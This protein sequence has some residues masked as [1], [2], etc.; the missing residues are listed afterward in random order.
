MRQTVR[1]ILVIVA[2]LLLS[3]C[4]AGDNRSGFEKVMD[5]FNMMGAGAF[6]GKGPTAFREAREVRE[7]KEQNLSQSVTSTWCEDSIIKDGMEWTEAREI[8]NKKYLSGELSGAEW[9]MQE[10]VVNLKVEPD[11]LAAKTKIGLCLTQLVKSKT[12]KNC[13]TSSFTAGDFSCLEAAMDGVGSAPSTS[14][15]SKVSNPKKR[16]YP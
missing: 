16:R 3:S 9:A 1:F 15:G 2:G 7:A 10:C 13:S 8:C 6:S 12:G 11:T 14:M 4:V 5:P